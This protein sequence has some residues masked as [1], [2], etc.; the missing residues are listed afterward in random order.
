MTEK[1][2]YT[3]I[4]TNDCLIFFKGATREWIPNYET[5]TI[6]STTLKRDLKPAVNKDGY[7]LVSL[8]CGKMRRTV[9]VHRALWVMKNGIPLNPA[10]EV[11]HINHNPRDNRLVNLRLVTCSE[12]HRNRPEMFA[13]AEAIRRDAAA[14]VSK[15][16]L[17]ERY[18]YSVH[19]IQDIVAKRRYDPAQYLGKRVSEHPHLNPLTGEVVGWFR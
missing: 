19:M 10:L 4:K 9:S 6:Y 5:G 14:G 3:R 12:N 2:R 8:R 17:S 13:R 18:G 11:D 1:A 7:H 16:E 15:K